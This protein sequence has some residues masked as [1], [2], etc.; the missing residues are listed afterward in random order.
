MESQVRLSKHVL[1][2]SIKT[3][4]VSKLV[5]F[6]FNYSQSNSWSI[7]WLWPKALQDT[8]VRIGELEIASCQKESYQS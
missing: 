6:I 3:Y 7:R 5:S 8:Q 4:F 2:Y 1:F